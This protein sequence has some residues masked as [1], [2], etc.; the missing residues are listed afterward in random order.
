M[1][2]WPRSIGCVATTTVCVTVTS[3][4]NRT[5]TGPRSV[6]KAT[7]I[8]WWPVQGETPPEHCSADFAASTFARSTGD[9]SI[10]SCQSALRPL[11]RLRCSITA[12]SM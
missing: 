11:L 10:A 8:R 2:T 5:R 9:T 12:R 1:I 7:T 3:A 4:S 6:E